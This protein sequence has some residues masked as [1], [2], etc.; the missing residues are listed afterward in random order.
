MRLKL[1]QGSRMGWTRIW[2][3]V[4]KHGSGKWKRKKNIKNSPRGQA[5]QGE[6]LRPKLKVRLKMQQHFSTEA[7]IRR[8]P[9]TA[10]KK[11]HLFLGSG[12]TFVTQG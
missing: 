1:Y 7:A 12:R 2:K 8:E 4:E 10:R 6:V 3:T 11:L 5:E 9:G